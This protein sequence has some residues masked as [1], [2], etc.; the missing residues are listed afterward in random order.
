M[1]KGFTW[2]LFHA[3]IQNSCQSC[4]HVLNKEE[5]QK[6]KDSLIINLV[7]KILSCFILIGI[8]YLI[9]VEIKGVL[10]FED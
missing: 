9:G 1:R 8:K 3:A 10:N 5:L 7:L 6:L 2:P 4:K